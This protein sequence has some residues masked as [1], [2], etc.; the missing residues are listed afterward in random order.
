MS[1]TNSPESDS[2]TPTAS[3]NAGLFRRLAAMLYDSLLVAALLMFGTL[4]VMLLS[5]L[6]ASDGVQ[7][8]PSSGVAGW[9]YQAF[10]GVI[11]V[12]FFTLFW[13]RSSRTLGMQ[14]WHLHIENQHGGPTTVAQ[15]IKRLLGALL[16]AACV[17]LGYLWILFDRDQCA[18]HDR[19]SGTRVRW[20]PK[21]KKKK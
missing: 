6:V 14:V 21:Q 15:A 3:L 16:S 17:G 8:V 1:S 5:S 19:L 4:S 9:L 12:G 13:V 10:L 18:W 7:A 11:V 2:S 20:I